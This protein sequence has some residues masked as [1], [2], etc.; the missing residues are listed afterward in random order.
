MRSPLLD[1]PVQRQMLLL[2]LS[3]A[4]NNRPDFGTSFD[5]NPD[6][7]V[8]KWISQVKAL[9][10][11]VGVSKSVEFRA[12]LQTSAQYW[13]PATRSIQIIAND[14]I[15]ELK[16]ELEL[17][18]DENIGR[19]YEAN[20]SHRFKTDVLNIVCNA[21]NEVFVVDP[22]LDSEI[23]A[24]LFENSGS[25]SIRALCSQYF[26]SASAYAK[27]FASQHARAAEVRKSKL[28]HDRLIFV[29]DDCW[30]VG[31]SLKDGG[32]KPTYLMPLPPELCAEKMRIYNDI[33][34]QSHP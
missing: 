2:K 9:V 31:A 22:Y 29:D 18:Q 12:T 27:S 25:F 28:L 11:R 32:T 7:P 16:L 14:A 1:G 33:W 17:Y 26:A 30:L 4:M 24:L 6:G 3:H 8:Q 23:F 20:E 15:E 10:D 34:V 21:S 19:I 13:Q 5:N